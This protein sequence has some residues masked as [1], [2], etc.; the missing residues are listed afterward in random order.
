MPP[1][2]PATEGI[3]EPDLDILPEHLLAQEDDLL[4]TLHRGL[5]LTDVHDDQLLLGLGVK[6]RPRA[7]GVQH[8]R[9]FTRLA[10]CLKKCL[11]NK[12]PSK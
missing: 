8:C 9:V 11:D 10:R 2:L 12:K 1:S 7:D 4:A 3:P 5:G 6:H